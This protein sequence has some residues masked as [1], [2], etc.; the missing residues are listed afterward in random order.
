MYGEY[1]NVLIPQEA[2]TEKAYNGYAVYC[3]FE[4]IGRVFELLSARS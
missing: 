3:P 2:K 4:K 1:E